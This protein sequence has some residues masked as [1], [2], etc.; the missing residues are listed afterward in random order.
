MR[1]SPRRLLLA[2]AAGALA[3]TGTVATTPAGAA[4]NAATLTHAQAVA[5]LKAADVSVSSSKHCSDRN[6]RGCTSLDGVRTAT[7]DGVIGLRRASGCD[8]TITGGTEVGH[9]ENG[10]Y[11]H[12][13]GYKVDVSLTECVTKHIERHAA[14]GE[15]RGDGAPQWTAPGVVYAKETAKHH[16]DITYTGGTGRSGAPT[17]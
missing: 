10:D 2:A 12:D 5:R 4:E 3:L 1:M 14:K 9:S 15:T 6:D 17:A 11:R 16:W 7:I 13:N 8:I